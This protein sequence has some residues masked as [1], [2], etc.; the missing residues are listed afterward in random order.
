MG[1]YPADDI[2][3]GPRLV[4]CTGGPRSPKGLLAY[5]GTG[6]LVVDVEVAAGVAQRPL[7]LYDRLAVLGKDRTGERIGG[8]GV[9]DLQSLLQLVILIDV[10]GYD[11]TEDLLNHGLIVGRLAPQDGGLYKPPLAVVAVTTRHNLALVGGLGPL[12]ITPAVLEGG[13]V[14]DGGHK[15]VELLYIPHLQGS[16]LFLQQGLQLRP[17]TGRHKGPGAGR[18]LLPLILKGAPNNGG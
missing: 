11:G 6:T 10:D 17:Q 12:Q 9:T 4:I 3:T 16:R 18:A 14:N 7:H 15:G 2:E 13:F 1:T 5:N 8:G